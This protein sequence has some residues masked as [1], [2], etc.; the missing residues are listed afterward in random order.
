[1]VDIQ[2]IVDT[3]DDDVLVRRGVDI[4][5]TINLVASNYPS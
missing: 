1:M 3:H 4:L 5:S 2:A